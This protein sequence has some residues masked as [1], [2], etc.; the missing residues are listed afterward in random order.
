MGGSISIEKGDKDC[1]SSDITFLE[2]QL[3][4]EDAQLDTLSLRWNTISPAFAE[5][6]A[7]LLNKPIT[8]ISISFYCENK[9]SLET[10]NAALLNNVNITHLNALL[11]GPDIQFQHDIK[12][13]SKVIELLNS[14]TTDTAEPESWTDSFASFFTEASSDLN[15]LVE[16]TTQVVSGLREN[17]GGLLTQFSNLNLSTACSSITCIPSFSSPD[18]EER[19]DRDRRKKID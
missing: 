18:N 8:Q 16:G 6:L 14:D 4:S 19:K 2:A 15:S 5:R 13:E 9:S 3:K 10:I 17:V 1:D 11:L 7:A 12:P